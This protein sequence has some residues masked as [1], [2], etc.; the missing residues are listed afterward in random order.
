MEDGHLRDVLSRLDPRARDA[1]RRVLIADDVY[2]SGMA[3]RLL[4]QRID[5]SNSL[6]D[7]IDMLTLDADARRTVVRLLGE[8]EA[9]SAS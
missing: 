9:R 1:V 4:R 6:A 7:L 5:H 8:L 3:E 2:R